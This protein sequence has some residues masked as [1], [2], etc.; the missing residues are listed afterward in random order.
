MKPQCGLKE[1]YPRFSSV[2]RRRMC[3]VIRIPVWKLCLY[4][5]WHSSCSLSCRLMLFSV[6]DDVFTNSVYIA[7]SPLPHP[8]CFK[9]KFHVLKDREILFMLHLSLC[10]L[11]HMSVCSIEPFV[12]PVSSACSLIYEL[13][14][15]P[16]CTGGSFPLGKRTAR[17][18]RKPTMSLYV[19]SH[20]MPLSSAQRQRSQ[21]RTESM[22]SLLCVGKYLKCSIRSPVKRLC[23]VTVL[24][25][26]NIR[27][28]TAH[29]SRWGIAL[30]YSYFH[31]YHFLVW[32]VHKNG[33]VLSLDT[34][35]RKVC[36]VTECVGSCF[37]QFCL[38]FFVQKYELLK[39]I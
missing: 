11:M 31:C 20:H 34:C 4:L 9:R 25:F 5:S 16:A 15:C 21:T 2:C 39:E 8:R 1:I 17:F 12:E 29:C 33:V 19:C 14:L 32:D 10:H 7:A 6:S 13:P 18:Y 26:S 24:T 27:N 28:Y 30:L 23:N 37:V 3:A 35:I 22:L 36:T 38:K